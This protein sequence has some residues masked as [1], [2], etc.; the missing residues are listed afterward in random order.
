MKTEIFGRNGED[1]R[2]TYI[3]GGVDTDALRIYNKR[4]IKRMMVDEK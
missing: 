4:N 2:G 3:I 1:G